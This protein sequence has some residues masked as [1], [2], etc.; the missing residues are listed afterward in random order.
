MLQWR[1]QSPCCTEKWD[2]MSFG[3]TDGTVSRYSNV[4]RY[5]TI[6]SPARVT[7]GERG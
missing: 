5:R 2:M 7:P 1:Q 4:F 6:G 3:G